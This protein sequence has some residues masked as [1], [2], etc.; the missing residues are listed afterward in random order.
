MVRGPLKD[1]VGENLVKDGNQARALAR[2]Q[3]RDPSGSKPREVVQRAPKA[4]GRRKVT[5]RNRGLVNEISVGP[6]VFQ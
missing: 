3:F 5:L 4:P 2:H 1:G 6:Q